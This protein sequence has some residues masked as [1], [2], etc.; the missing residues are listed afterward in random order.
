MARVLR[1][2][3]RVELTRRLFILENKRD[4][5]RRKLKED[6]PSYPPKARVNEIRKVSA[7]ITQ[8]TNHINDMIVNRY[9]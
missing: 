6:H 1:N 5:M 7:K 3:A 4:G 2:E 8:I 9:K